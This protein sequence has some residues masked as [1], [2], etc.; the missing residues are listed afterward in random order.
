MVDDQWEMY[1]G[2]NDKSAHFAK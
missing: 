1:D 2:F